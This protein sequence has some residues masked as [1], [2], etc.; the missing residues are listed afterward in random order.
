MHARRRG[1]ARRQAKIDRSAAIGRIERASRRR[2]HGTC[3]RDGGQ[4]DLR[5]GASAAQGGTG[6]RP[7]RRE[8]LDRL[9]LTRRDGDDRLRL[10]PN[11]PSRSSGRGKRAGEPPLQPS[12]PAIRQAILDI[13]ARPP[14]IRCPHGKTHIAEH[15][16][17]QS[18]KT[19]LVLRV[20][21]KTCHPVTSGKR[22]HPGLNH[23]R[24]ALSTRRKSMK[25]C[26]LRIIGF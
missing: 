2:A 4:M 14:P 16:E 22:P 8:M 15:V 13:F 24:P 12:M 7:L 5:A 26:S 23:G 6:P 17:P 18:A 19:A 1:W 21:P 25:Y 10:P 9:T 3:R 20:F 11:P